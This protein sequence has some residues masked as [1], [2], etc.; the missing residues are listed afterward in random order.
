MWISA[1]LGALAGLSFTSTVLA[2]T[3]DSNYFIIKPTLKAGQK[4]SFSLNDYAMTSAVASGGDILQYPVFIPMKTN[5]QT[6]FFVLRSSHGKYSNLVYDTVYP[7]QIGYFNMTAASLG[8]T[9]AWQ[10][11]GVYAVPSSTALPKGNFYINETSG[12]QWT[13]DPSATGQGNVFTGWLGKISRVTPK[14]DV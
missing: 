3:T 11:V 4:P 6:Q 1:V 8:A 2:E 7:D 12:L 14:Y 5:P 9:A 13:S 10:T